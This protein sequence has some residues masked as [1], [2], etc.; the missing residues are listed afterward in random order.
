MKNFSRKYFI[1]ILLTILP[2]FQSTQ[3]LA[4]PL[5]ELGFD[6]VLYI[7]HPAYFSSHFYSFFVDGMDE[8]KG[9]SCFHKDNGIYYIDLKS[10]SETPVIMASDKRLPGDKGIFGRYDLSYDATKIVFDYRATVNTGFRIYE[11]DITGEN[12][13][14]LTFDPPWEKDVIKKY[15]HIRE[16]SRTYNKH[17]DDMH[18][19]YSPDGKIIF[20]STRVM[21]ETFC[22]ASGVLSTA[23]LHRLDPTYNTPSELEASIE[24]ISI[25]GVSEFAP[26][27]LNDGRIIFTRWE[28][29]DKS[30]VSIKTLWSIYPDGSKGEEVFGLNHNLPS[31]FYKAR[32]VPGIDHYV[33]CDGVPHYPQ[34]G[35]GTVLRIDTR[36]DIRTKEPMELFTPV[37]MDNY[38][39]GWIYKKGD[40]WVQAENGVGCKLYDDPYPLNEKQVLV[41]CKYNESDLWDHSSAYGIYLIDEDGYHEEILNPKHTSCWVPYPLKPRPVPPKLSEVVDQNLKD[42]NRALVILTDVNR[43]L[44]GVPKGTVKY[45]RVN[46]QIPRPWG[47]NTRLWGYNYS[48]T[49]PQKDAHMWIR[50]QRGVAKVEDDGSAQFYVPADRSLFFEALDSNYMSVQRERTWVNFRPG[51]IRSCI[52]CHE[53]TG[54]SPRQNHMPLALSLPP[55]ELGPQPGEESGFRLIHYESDVQPIWD[56]HCIECHGSK[57]PAGNLNLTDQPRRDLNASYKNLK[58]REAKNGKYCIGDYVREDD[59]NPY[60]DGEYRE[61][62]SFGAHTSWLVDMLKEGHQSVKLSKEEMIKIYTWMDNNIQYYGHYYGGRLEGEEYYRIVISPEEALLPT[63]PWDMDER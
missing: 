63:A 51:E 6:K 16:E 23:N 25:N 11:I 4:N 9:R 8:G 42:Q 10:R 33:F 49:N 24:Q 5:D 32:A 37:F 13:R 21:Y 55:Q 58:K 22:N 19:C 53:R 48:P 54:E 40:L 28:Y 14:Q 62:Y 56:K 57:K 39:A 20:T 18:P 30:S 44:K 43:G 45:I 34:G 36:K 27:V 2:F 60:N 31:T 50:L 59:P 26:S 7:K 61:A 47:S 17:I 1:G 15:G 29:L 3:T 46:E 35:V 38:E 41:A 52:G 12:L